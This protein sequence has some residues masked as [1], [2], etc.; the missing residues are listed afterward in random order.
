MIDWC[1]YDN[2]RNYY[3]S[4]LELNPRK[5]KAT[6][7]SKQD[8]INSATRKEHTADSLVV[9]NETVVVVNQSH[10]LR[11]IDQLLRFVGGA[12]LTTDREDVVGAQTDVAFLVA[13]LV[14]G[15]HNVGDG[16]VLRL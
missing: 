6:I 12:N 2:E 16:H 10:D 11:E 3:Q 13:A 5:T 4:I 7:F 8:T 1:G 9:D 15:D 14:V